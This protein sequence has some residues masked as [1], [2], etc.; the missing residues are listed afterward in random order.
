[1]AAFLA[2]ALAASSLG[3]PPGEN[4]PPYTERADIYVLSIAPSIEALPTDL[5]GFFASRPDAL[6]QQMRSSLL[7]LSSQPEGTRRHFVMLDAG[8]ASNDDAARPAA[9]RSFPRDHHDADDLFR[10]SN[11]D[12]GAL[13]WVIIDR[14]QAL[15]GAFRSQQVETILS[16]SADLLHLCVDAC[17]PFHVT[18]LRDQ[19]TL[20]LRRLFEDVLP[21][22]LKKR[23]KYEARVLPD[24]FEKSARPIDCVFDAA[25]EAHGQL[26]VITDAEA[27]IRR[28]LNLDDEVDIAAHVDAY[29][30]SVTERLGPLLETQIERGALLAARLIGTSWLEA[31]SPKLPLAIPP[32][33]ASESVNTASQPSGRSHASPATSFVGSS[34]S[35]TFH[36]PD[37]AHAARIKLEN[38]MVFETA[39][40]A[41]SNGRKPCKA[42]KPE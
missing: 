10:R 37:C 33:S 30:A 35:K 9:A 23:L 14:Q 11:V 15:V 16:G 39:A 41:K 36:R 34:S 24:R 12:G 17:L 19:Q 7:H 21:A 13:P 2:I 1:M 3:S 4:A 28:D 8:A 5:R 42:C 25:I 27:A 31:G 32:P 26:R 18:Q 40:K 6:E 20:D 22:R 38:R 29:Y